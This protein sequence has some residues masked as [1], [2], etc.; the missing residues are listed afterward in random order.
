MTPMLSIIVP[1]YNGA[2]YLDRLFEAFRNQEG[3]FLPDFELICI[4]DGS[5]DNSLELLSQ[6]VDTEPYPVTVWT[7]P[8]KGVSNARNKGMEFCR[9]KYVAFVDCDDLVSSQ[10]LKTF[11][12]AVLDKRPKVVGFRSK[13]TEKAPKTGSQSKRTA[14]H[15]MPGHDM[16]RKVAE[17][18]TNFG[19]YNFFYDAGFLKENGLQF[20]V[21]YDYYEDYDFIFRVLAL[22][23]TVSYTEAQ[24]YYY[25]LEEGTAVAQ[26]KPARVANIELL[27]NLVP[28]LKE[29]A[30][31]FVEEYETHVIPRIYWSILW[32]ASLAFPLIDAL[33]FAKWADMKHQLKALTDA[34]C[35]KVSLSSKLY[36]VPVVGPTAF[37][38]AARLLGRNRSKI[39]PADL[40]DFKDC[41]PS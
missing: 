31:E 36:E 33:R 30:P 37:I 1:V 34:P 40:E 4:N 22:A 28:F 7:I 20:A 10:Y 6:H 14:F 8:N 26:F 39:T 15:L 32:Q 21:G 24:L 29:Q 23:D 5:T 3:K 9:G 38:T 35:V 2:A 11:S 27:Q 25:M 12:E 18:P 13:R 17:N 16:L 19:V 41:F